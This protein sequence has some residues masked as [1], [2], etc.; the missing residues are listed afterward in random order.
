[1][2]PA[3]YSITYPQGSTLKYQL[4]YMIGRF[5]VNLT[6]YSARLQ[7]RETHRSPNTL[8]SLT[9]ENGIT[10][11]DKQG[12]IQIVIPADV[13][14]YFH[15]TNYVYDLELVSPG[16]EVTRI[17]EGTFKVTPEVTR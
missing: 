6:G 16:G 3:K 2:N 9:T 10:L 7:V 12:T 17:L 1:M 15:P 14:T 5:P 11:G 13:T 4:T 8:V